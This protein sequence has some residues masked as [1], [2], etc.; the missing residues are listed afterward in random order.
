MQWVGL[1]S[2][3]LTQYSAPTDCCFI[4]WNI[5]SIVLVA[6]Q[7]GG[8][9]GMLPAQQCPV[10]LEDQ[11]AEEAHITTHEAQPEPGCSWSEGKH[12][13]PH[14]SRYCKYDIPLLG[15]YSSQDCASAHWLLLWQIQQ[16]HSGF[17]RHETQTSAKLLTF[18][19][20]AQCSGM[21]FIISNDL[22]MAHQNSFRYV[23]P[24]ARS[25]QSICKVPINI[26]TRWRLASVD[27]KLDLVHGHSWK[28]VP[29]RE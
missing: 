15:A 21:C 27:Q 29:S 16:T 2:H 26:S 6:P 1:N 23:S 13:N 8:W 4:M 3:K 25:L 5:F 10:Q 24:A 18:T 19:K 7:E 28:I 17:H 20:N 14:T 11:G 12:P 9:T 22:Y